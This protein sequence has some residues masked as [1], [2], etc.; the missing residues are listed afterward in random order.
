VLEDLEEPRCPETPSPGLSWRRCPAE[1]VIHILSG[2]VK[3][4]TQ[5][6]V[7]DGHSKRIDIWAKIKEKKRK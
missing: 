7:I 6:V 5:I 2:I 4:C 1:I 3:L